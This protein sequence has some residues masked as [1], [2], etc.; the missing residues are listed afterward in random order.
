M[1]LLIFLVLIILVIILSGIIS[2]TEAAILSIS[3]TKAKEILNKSKG[4]IAKKKA[5]NLLLIKEN[6]SK[7]ITTIVV[8]NNIVNIV[9]SIYIGVLASAIFGQ[10]YLGLISGIL[11]FLI[12][13]FSEIIPKIYGEKHSSSI[14]LKMSGFIIF[15]TKL[16][17]PI[18]YI[19][20]KISNFFIKGKSS[21]EI[22][23]GEIEEMAKMGVQTGSIEKHESEVIKNVFRMNDTPVYDIMVPK[24]KS[25]F[26]E[27]TTN[28]KEIIEIIQ[29]TGF[30]RF[31]ITKNGEIIGL[32]NA[33]DL[34]KFN[35]DEENF[36][37]SKII[38]PI[39]FAPESQK[40]FTLE[41]TLKKN[42]IHM[43]AIVNEHGDVT[44]IVTLEDIIEELL[45]EIE[46]EFDRDGDEFI[47]KITDKKYEIN[48]TIDID[49]INEKFN[50][51]LPMDEEFSTLNGYLISKFDHIPKANEVFRIN[52]FKFRVLSANKKRIIKVE[53]YLY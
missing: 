24:N 37:I 19:L 29:K 13:M 28:F 6:L 21:M 26:I 38:R 11:T 53:L 49:I 23:E 48:S 46:D 42:R 33:K 7:Y 32:I 2:G 44:G 16:F 1:G 35:G 43:A 45:G 22:S 52:E 8:M 27:K 18:N 5:Q 47:T 31:P 50:L 40:I 30:T 20:N 15:L 12:I 34:F 10:V 17:T 9:G 3:Y 36:T 14:S 41:E 25:I 39:I 51:K 4:K